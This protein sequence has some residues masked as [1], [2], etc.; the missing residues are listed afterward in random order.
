MIH[1]FTYLKPGSVKEAFAMLADHAMNVRSL[2]R[3]VIAH[4]KRQ[5]LLR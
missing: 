2:R 5:G 1:D 3:A 4:C